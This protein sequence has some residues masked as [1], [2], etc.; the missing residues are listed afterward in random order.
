[1]KIRK[2]ANT[3]HLK[4]ETPGESFFEPKDDALFWNDLY[5]ETSDAWLY[6]YDASRNR[7]CFL[8]DYGYNILDELKTGQMIVLQYHE[9]DPDYEFNHG[10]K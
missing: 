6:L 10:H 4:L 1:M 8:N 5:I 3:L 9:N 7:V 2:F